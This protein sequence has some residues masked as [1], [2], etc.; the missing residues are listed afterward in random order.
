MSLDLETPLALATFLANNSN[1]HKVFIPASFN[2]S[3]IMTNIKHQESDILVC[4]KDFYLLK[5]PHTKLDEYR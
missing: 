5:P 1:L 3:K 4:D 2:M